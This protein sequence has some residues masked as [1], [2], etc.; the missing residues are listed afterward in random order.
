MWI[1]FHCQF[2]DVYEVIDPPPPL[3]I[4]VEVPKDGSTGWD[5]LKV[6]GLLYETNFQSSHII[7]KKTAVY[8]GK[9]KEERNRRWVGR[10][11]RN[12]KWET[13]IEHGPMFVCV[14]FIV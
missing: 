12:R 3:P 6:L 11:E 13:E 14:C 5:S 7:T 8:V 2:P 1:N 9:G 4:D 10:R